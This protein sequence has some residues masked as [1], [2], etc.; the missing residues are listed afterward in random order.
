MGRLD[1]K[2]A[3]ITG[4]AS[5]IGRAAVRKLAHEGAAVVIADIDLAGAGVVSDA[6]IAQGGRALAVSCDIR[7]EKD[8]AAAVQAAVDSFGRIDIMFNNAAALPQ[9]IM[10]QD[11]DILTIGTQAWDDLMAGVLRS[12]MLGCRYAVI[13]MR[14]TGGGSIINT[15]SMYGVSAFNRHPGYGTAKAGVI[16]LSQYVATAFGRDNIRCNAIAPSMVRT[17]LLERTAPEPLIELNAANVLTPSLGTPEDI[18]DIVA[19]LASE[20]SRYLTGHLF[21]ADGG[22]TAHLPTYS[23]AKR[24][25]E[26]LEV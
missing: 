18:A 16:M 14:K 7:I 6:V 17:E 8:I 12:V 22:T 11:I 23:E 21:R 10:V 24:F 9:E 15:S 13:E 26:S 5:G 3:V 20:E 4:G 2:V 1:D 25:Y 19:F